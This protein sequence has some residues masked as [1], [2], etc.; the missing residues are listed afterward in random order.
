MGSDLESTFDQKFDPNS[1]KVGLKIAFE[2][3]LEKYTLSGQKSTLPKSKNIA[4][5]L[6]GCS[7]S[8]FSYIRNF[9]EKV[10]LRPL[11]LERFLEPKS[12]QDREKTIS[13]SQ[14]KSKQIFIRFFIDLGSILDP[15][16]H[17]EIDDF[18]LILPLGVDLE[19]SWR[20]EG[21]QSVPRQPQSSIFKDLGPSWRGFWNKFQQI[22]ISA[23]NQ[24]F[25]VSARWRNVARSA[26]DI[27][28]YFNNFLF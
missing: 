15:I 16:G 26:L 12:I 7:K 20:Q 9:V 21:P 28:I 1:K 6:E 22:P 25:Q 23:L 19:P 13:K 5:P 24:N 18:S 10:T 11:I 17:P 8:H 14:Q 27:Y 4:K 3:T 2:K